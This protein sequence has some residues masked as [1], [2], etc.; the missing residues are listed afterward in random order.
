MAVSD[1]SIRQSTLIHVHVC[2]QC[3]GVFRREEL[4]GRMHTTGI[5]PNFA[6]RFS[7]VARVAALRGVTGD[8][9][10][11]AGSPPKP[12]RPYI[13]RLIAFSRLI[14]PSIGPLLHGVVIDSFT[15]SKSR[16]SVLA[17]WAVK[18]NP[19]TVAESIHLFSFLALRQRS[20]ARN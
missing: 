17:N 19:E 7:Q 20:M 8:V 2:I 1:S 3:G 15:A 6:L 10:R 12:A 16:R 18:R 4:E 9:Y 5:F 14:C 13:C 11:V